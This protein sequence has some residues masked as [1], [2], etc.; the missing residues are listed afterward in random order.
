MPHYFGHDETIGPGLSPTP[1][2]APGTD[3]SKIT[4]ADLINK[5]TI[6][7][8]LTPSPTTP[9]I[10]GGFV[11]FDSLQEQVGTSAKTQDTENIFKLFEKY[12]P[13]PEPIAPLFEEA[14]KG[15]APFQQTLLGRE[16][17]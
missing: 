14:Q 4:S 16:N 6:N 11:T 17:K 3:L 1:T 7:V 15:L 2:F 9:D 12:S 13:K 5:G 8:P 10:A